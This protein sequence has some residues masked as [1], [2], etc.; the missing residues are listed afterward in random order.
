MKVTINGNPSQEALKNFAKE[1]KRIT[2]KEQ[3]K[4]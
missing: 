2:E 1:L 3:L 4:K